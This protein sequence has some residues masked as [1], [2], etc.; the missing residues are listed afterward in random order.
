MTEERTTADQLL[1]I[2]AD[3]FVAELGSVISR[4]SFV[5][6][7]ETSGALYL[8]FREPPPPPSPYPAAFYSAEEWLRNKRDQLLE[9][10]VIE[11]DYGAKRN[12]YAN[13]SSAKLVQDLAKAIKPVCDLP[14]Q[15][16]PL[17][18]ATM[19][20]KIGL[21]EFCAGYDP[22][23][24]DS[25]NWSLEK[26]LGYDRLKANELTHK[27]RALVRAGRWKRAVPLLESA[28]RFCPLHF[29]AL[30]DL[31][32][33][34]ARYYPKCDKG[35]EY[36][37][38]LF[39]QAELSGHMEPEVLDTI[40]WAGFR[41]GGKI[42]IVEDVLKR[43]EM[44]IR[45]GESGYITIGYH[46]MAVLAAQEKYS[47]ARRLFEKFSKLPATTTIDSESLHAA[48]QLRNTFPE[49]PQIR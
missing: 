9:A 47:D 21:D 4:L 30:N 13:Q 45:N 19:L 15:L 5:H 27:A 11:F 25:Q 37:R 29:I 40:G 44:S 39:R 2:P 43:A 49:M 48:K 26:A 23:T 1:S 18:V 3:D 6:E 17:L 22:L 42:N 8:P 36:G 35:L 41:H 31:T 28:L 46:L 33:I 38:K 20:V 7:M 16:D 10:I 24:S 14:Y 34:Y 12:R 32:D